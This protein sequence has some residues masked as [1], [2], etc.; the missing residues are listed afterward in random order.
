VVAEV[1]RGREEYAALARELGMTPQ[2]SATNFVALDVGSSARAKALL[3][4]LAEQGVFI[5]MPGAAPLDRCVRVTVGTAAERA[6][7]AE[8]LRAIWPRVARDAGA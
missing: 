2:P 5:R 1:A 4:A 3:A 6:A 7:F 8:I